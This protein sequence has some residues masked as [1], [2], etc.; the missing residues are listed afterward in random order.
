MGTRNFL[1]DFGKKCFTF[2]LIGITISDRLASIAHVQGLSMCPTFN[3]NVR[4]FM[5]SLAGNMVKIKLKQA[6]S[7]CI[8]KSIAI[9]ILFYADDYVLLEKLCLEK[10]KFSH[11]DVIAFR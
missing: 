6:L 10:Y 11:G 2:G 7:S 5:G 1:W 9:N 3:P 8:L 4:T